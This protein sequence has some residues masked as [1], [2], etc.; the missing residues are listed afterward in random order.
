VYLSPLRSKGT[1]TRI[2][3]SG[4]GRR[5]G[6]FIQ[7]ELE[8]AANVAEIVES[9]VAETVER[10]Q[11]R[12]CWIAFCV[13]IDHA[14]A[15]RDAIRRPGINCE[16]VTAETPGDERHAVFAAFRVPES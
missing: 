6:E 16:T 13:G 8:R 15:V 3:I 12:R 5:G 11:D 7:N 14:Y 10:G 4:V 9:A 2:D 1:R